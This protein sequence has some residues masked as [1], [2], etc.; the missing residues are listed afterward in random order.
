MKNIDLNKVKT[1]LNERDKE[2]KLLSKVKVQY[3]KLSKKVDE[4]RRTMNSIDNTVMW[5][6]KYEAIVKAAPE[7]K[8]AFLQ[9]IKD[10]ELKLQSLDITVR[11]Q[12][13]LLF[14]IDNLMQ[15]TKNAPCEHLILYQGTQYVEDEYG[16]DHGYPYRTCC[17]C[18]FTESDPG[19][20]RSIYKVLKDKTNRFV[21]DYEC[22]KTN[23]INKKYSL[24]STEELVNMFIP[25]HIF[26]IIEEYTE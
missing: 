25:K 1:L 21:F 8:Q 26:A 10:I 18:D 6:K 11:E 22:N 15:Q 9:Q 4:H 7:N 23:A 14:Q 24:L 13:N 12:R 3:D 19:I 16:S 2:E 5:I 20:G 17:I